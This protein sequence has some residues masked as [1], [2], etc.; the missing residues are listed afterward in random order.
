M[1]SVALCLSLLAAV[2]TGITAQN[3]TDDIPDTTTYVTVF[4]RRCQCS[5][6][7]AN[8]KSD[9]TFMN[10]YLN[11]VLQENV[12]DNIQ[13]T[14]DSDPSECRNDVSQRCATHCK[15]VGQELENKLAF[16]RLPPIGDLVCEHVQWQNSRWRYLKVEITSL[17]E[18]DGAPRSERRLTARP[19]IDDLCC[20]RSNDDKWTGYQCQRGAV[21]G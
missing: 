13:M 5:L 11:E 21:V 7:A 14:F 2:I 19:L 18:C 1:A 6:R 17:A 16:K 12:A 10:K 9:W 15:S 4:T 20:Q 3:S 8:A